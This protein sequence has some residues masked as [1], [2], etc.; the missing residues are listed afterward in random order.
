MRRKGQGRH[1]REEEGKRS[2]KDGK[3]KLT[4]N[5]CALKTQGFTLATFNDF[6]GTPSKR[7]ALN[8]LF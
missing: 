6:D 4:Y 3:N 7:T 8:F 2:G 1:G 5:S